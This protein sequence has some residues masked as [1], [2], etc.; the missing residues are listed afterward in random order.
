MAP[1]SAEDAGA[2]SMP[3]ASP[4]K[5]HL[6]HTTWFFE[7]F[8]LAAFEP[9][10]APVDPLFRTLFNSYY[11]A[12]GARIPRAQRGLL[13]RPPLSQVL[14]YRAAIDA[15]MQRLIDAGAL[16]ARALALIELGLQHEQQHQEL[17]LTDLLHL[18]SRNPLA[19]AYRPGAVSAEPAAARALQWIEFKGGLVWCGHDPADDGAFAFDNEGP[20]HRAWLAPF[21]IADRLVTQG[22]FAE[23]IEAGGY[24]EP[25]W[26]LA[27]GWDWRQREGITRPL[28]WNDDGSVFT[29]AGCVARAPA[30]PVCHLSYFEADAYAR[31]ADARLPTEAEWEHA[32]RACAAQD[33]APSAASHDGPAGDRVTDAISDATS[34]PIADTPP[35]CALAAR[36]TGMQWFGACWQWTSSAYA[37]YPGFAPAPG[38]VGEYNGKFMV[39]QQVLRG[40]ACSTPPGHARASYRNFFPAT[41]R[42]QFAGLRLARSLMR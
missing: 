37:P 19:P 9:G 32:A 38:A 26:W 2:Q 17:I 7:T 20:R 36:D 23:F 12:V 5:W 34:D 6:A 24:R 16:P 14:D 42:W 35:L 41:A 8:V 29:L 31:W 30:Q 21:A 18:L 1:L 10:F 15:R 13:T 33:A 11:D 40:S 27:E 22:E 4:A 25:Q 3:D 28:Y 39:N